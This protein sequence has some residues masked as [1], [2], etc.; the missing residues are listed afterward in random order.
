MYVVSYINIIWEYD[1]ERTAVNTV[2]NYWLIEA[3]N[4]CLCRA[5]GAGYGRAV[6]S[7]GAC[8]ARPPPPLFFPPLSVEW[9]HQVL[10]RAA[11]R[12]GP[13]GTCTC[14]TMT[15]SCRN[16]SDGCRRPPSLTRVVA[17]SPSWQPTACAAGPPA[18]ST[19]AT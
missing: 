13:R 9:A 4:S 2:T 7:G 12:E 1:R 5:A 14:N 17:L 15:M 10:S 3:T 6:G 19:R 18:L 8:G 11:G 16:G